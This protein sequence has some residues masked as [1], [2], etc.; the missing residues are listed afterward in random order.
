[1]DSAKPAYSGLADDGA[2][3]LTRYYDDLA[4][5]Y[6][7]G[8]QLKPADADPL[9]IASMERRETVRF[10][11][12]NTSYDVIRSQAL[13]NE[14]NGEWVFSRN[15][16]GYP[17]PPG[18][19]YSIAIDCEPSQTRYYKRKHDAI[20]RDDDFRTRK[21]ILNRSVRPLSADA[22]KRVLHS[23]RVHMAEIKSKYEGKEKLAV[24]EV[25]G[26]KGK[27]KQEPQVE[28]VKKELDFTIGFEMKVFDEAGR[29]K[30]EDS[31]G[32]FGGGQ[33]ILP[34]D[35]NAPMVFKIDQDWLNGSKIKAK[36]G[37]L[38]PDDGRF[39]LLDAQGPVY[40]SFN[41][42][43]MFAP[44]AAE[45]DDGEPAFV[46]AMYKWYEAEARYDLVATKHEYDREAKTLL[47]HPVNRSSPSSR[48][49]GLG[50]FSTDQRFTDEE[51]SANAEMVMHLWVDEADPALAGVADAAGR[52][53]N[54]PFKLALRFPD[55]LR[56]KS[57]TEKRVDRRGN[58]YEP[59][60]WEGAKVIPSYLRERTP[61]WAAM[62]KF[63]KALETSIQDRAAREQQRNEE[64]DG[65]AR[66]A[67]RE[68]DGETD[69]EDDGAGGQVAMRN[70]NDKRVKMVEKERERLNCIKNV[71]EL[72]HDSAELMRM[73]TEVNYELVSKSFLDNQQTVLNRIKKKDAAPITGINTMLT[74]RMPTT[75]DY[76]KDRPDMETVY[77][78]LVN[79]YTMEYESRRYGLRLRPER[80]G[81]F[82]VWRIYQKLTRGPV[83]RQREEEE[84]PAGGAEVWPGSESSED[85]ENEGG[86]WNEENLTDMQKGA[87]ESF[88]NEIEKAVQD[89][90]DENDEDLSKILELIRDR[91]ITT[92]ATI[93]R[94]AIQRWL[95]DNTINEK[96]KQK[97]EITKQYIKE[98]MNPYMPMQLDVQENENAALAAVKKVEKKILIYTLK[99]RVSRWF[100]EIWQDFQM[101]KRNSH[102]QTNPGLVL[103]KMNTSDTTP[104]KI[105]SST[106]LSDST[107]FRLQADTAP[108]DAGADPAEAEVEA[109]D[110]P[111]ARSAYNPRFDRE[112]LFAT[113]VINPSC[114][115]HDRND[116]NFVWRLQN[117]YLF[118][119]EEL[120]EILEN[121][122]YIQK[123]T[124]YYAFLETFYY[125]EG[126]PRDMSKFE[127]DLPPGS[128]N[129]LETV[130]PNSI[131]QDQK[132]ELD[133]YNASSMLK[134]WDSS[135][136]RA[137][138]P[139]IYDCPDKI[140]MTLGGQR[141]SMYFD[142]SQRTTVQYLQDE[143]NMRTRGWPNCIWGVSYYYGAWSIFVEYT[144]K[145]PY[146]SRMRPTATLFT[147]KNNLLNSLASIK[148]GYKI[149]PEDRR[150]LDNW[151]IQ[152]SNI[153]SLENPPF[154]M[155]NPLGWFNIDP[156]SAINDTQ[157]KEVYPIPFR[158]YNNQMFHNTYDAVDYTKP[159]DA[160]L[161]GYM[162]VQA[163]PD[164]FA[165]ACPLPGGP[166]QGSCLPDDSWEEKMLARRLKRREEHMLAKRLKDSLDLERHIQ[167][168]E[169]SEEEP[170]QSAEDME[171]MYDQIETAR[172]RAKREAES[173]SLL[174]AAALP[175][176]PRKLVTVPASLLQSFAG[177]C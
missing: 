128:F 43:Y 26:K 133:Q 107:P 169:E 127:R 158:F 66:E 145:L 156:G 164:D 36:G 28:V 139:L 55:Y 56:F 151:A 50:Y 130:L 115:I 159:R 12:I 94:G 175:L 108:A 69:E 120:T 62:N 147:R 34:R 106:A 103:Y 82:Y 23:E 73:R 52:G 154:S 155:N 25:K 21:G 152:Y 150:R 42:K 114:L 109:E 3:L 13:V 112:V 80:L 136:L 70:M 170:E 6:R 124:M 144:G 98:V 31:K 75:Y 146:P 122:Q 86:A 141:I 111:A 11:E 126:L 76:A 51:L 61:W 118:E 119:Q 67:R 54:N 64:R 18:T 32:R 121:E 160:N 113:K 48:W 97:A 38:D 149:T 65:V 137:R 33:I 79:P 105:Q 123:R 134:I 92:Y 142:R 53:T 157:E 174:R 129:P 58:E 165:P 40:M 46:W 57:K 60:T 4:R 101:A 104:F 2:L 90:T 35:Y 17:L 117:E 135:T 110:Y 168:E 138:P 47:H 96:N 37:R 125:S 20:A 14:T 177:S 172:L 99:K 41:G 8:L 83:H 1:V 100:V 167:P 131:M 45:G 81:S 84:R 71:T 68:M 30:M 44:H 162:R 116:A 166:L 176:Q 132:A 39:L 148:E 87:K 49:R 9:F 78:A 161:P 140:E 171:A 16:E 10:P 29:K 59:L 91:Y 74:V 24:Q 143:S 15:F 72:M 93:P 5:E 163:T 63:R 89:Y 85:E 102:D 22:W 7:W 19:D 77:F 88:K 153:Q 95:D 27:K 173:V